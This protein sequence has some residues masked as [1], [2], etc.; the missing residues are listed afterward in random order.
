MLHEH[1]ACSW[2]MITRHWH[3]V[4]DII[5]GHAAWKCSMDMRHGHAASTC[6]MDM[7]YGQTTRTCGVD[8]QH[9]HAAPMSVLL[10]HVACPCTMPM[11]LVHSACPCCMC[12]MSLL[13]V[14]RHLYH[15]WYGKLR[16]IV[17]VGFKFSSSVS[18]HS[19]EESHKPHVCEK[20]LTQFWPYGSEC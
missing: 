16:T 13:H 1:A 20:D 12:R 2:H 11:L 19:R 7:Q 4:L 17:H 5:H 3:A 18:S 9:G 10:V 8:M 14:H 6:S 15:V